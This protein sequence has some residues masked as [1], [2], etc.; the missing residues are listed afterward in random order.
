MSSEELPYI[1]R[2]VGSSTRQ[3]MEAFLDK[4]SWKNNKRL[5]LTSNEAVKQA[6]IANLGWSLMPL[7]GLQ[8]ELLNGQLRLIEHKL[9]PDDST[10]HIVWMKNKKLSPS[11]QEFLNYI[12]NE[13]EEL[14]RSFFDM[15]DS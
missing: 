7:I 10:W 15:L 6:V 9:L 3:V 12:R 14:R 13:K 4:Y 2:E 1:F 8:N 5:E 11:A